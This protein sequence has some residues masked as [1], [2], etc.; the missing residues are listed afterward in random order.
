MRT[1]DKWLWSPVWKLLYNREY[2]REYNKQY[3]CGNSYL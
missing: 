3:F 2:S 1:I